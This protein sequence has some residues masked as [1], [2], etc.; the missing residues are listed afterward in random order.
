MM[1][2]FS[3]IYTSL[4]NI[5]YHSLTQGSLSHVVSHISLLVSPIVWCSETHS[6]THLETCSTTVTNG[7]GIDLFTGRPDPPK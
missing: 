4:F 6:E 3:I 5:S 2:Q 1:M 7:Q